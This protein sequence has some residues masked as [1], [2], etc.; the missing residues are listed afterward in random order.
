MILTG[1]NQWRYGKIIWIMEKESSRFLWKTR[2]VNLLVISKPIYV[3]SI[4][5]I[6]ENN[7]M[8][9]NEK[10]C[11]LNFIWNKHDRIRR[12]TV[13]GKQENGGKGY[14]DI[15]LRLSASLVKRLTDEPNVINN[16]VNSYLN[17]MKIDLNY[18]LK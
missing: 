15:E 16:L 18:C 6:P 11:F 2:V 12:D 4:S 1:Y 3:C 8:K 7:L 10:D 9:E 13:I 5:P 17:V 14:V